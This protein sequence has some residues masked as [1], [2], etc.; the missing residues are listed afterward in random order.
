MVIELH[1]FIDQASQ[2]EP[3]GYRRPEEVVFDDG[4]SFANYMPSA[5]GGK[6]MRGVVIPHAKQY[7]GSRAYDPHNPPHKRVHI[8]PHIE[9]QSVVVD[10]AQITQDV[11]EEAMTLG[12]EY[13]DKHSDQVHGI[14]Q[15]RLKSAA[16]FHLI[17]AAQRAQNAKQPPQ[18]AAPSQIISVPQ[19]GVAGPIPS[20]PPAE[21]PRTIKAASFNGAASHEPAV[22]RGGL[23]DAYQRPRAQPVDIQPSASVDPPT[24]KVTFGVPG[25]G[26]HEAYYHDVI[27]NSQ[28]FILVYD[29]RY[30][31]ASKFLPQIDGPFAARVDGD[32][33][34]YRL[35][36]PDQSFTDP[37][38]GRTYFQLLIEERVP[39][40][41][42]T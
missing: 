21:G 16:A 6:S 24:K 38:T 30:K 15:L 22:P 5:V 4:T 1:S 10:L 26:L 14:D 18:P 36:W 2:K 25:F 19:A 28:Q 29:E 3:T 17:G 33:L 9:G 37:T 41:E 35:V 23:L 39:Q 32:P 34:D 12:Q 13:A 11:A 42:T 8:D 7:G 31:G 27:I 40:G 20:A